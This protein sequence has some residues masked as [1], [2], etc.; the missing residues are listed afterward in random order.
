IGQYR[1]HLISDESYQWAIEQREKARRGFAECIKTLGQRL[2]GGA[3][4]EAAV[5]VYRRAI[6]VDSLAEP[7]YLR[8]MVCLRELGRTGEAQETYRSL[9]RMLSVVLGLAPSREAH[10]VFQSLAAAR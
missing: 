5:A 10:S 3:H 9:R 6:E 7:F 8:L 1:G 4:W 2:E